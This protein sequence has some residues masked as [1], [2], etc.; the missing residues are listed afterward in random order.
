MPSRPAL[1]P[2]EEVAN[3]YIADDL[4]PTCSSSSS[5]I[6]CTHAAE[7]N[8]LDSDIDP[9]EDD[10][11]AGSQRDME[12]SDLMMGSVWTDSK[13]SSYLNFM[14]QNFVR[15]LYE[16]EYCA[17]DVCGQPSQRHEPRVEEAFDPDSAQSRSAAP[18]G[19]MEFKVWENGNWTRRLEWK[20]KVQPW[21]L[22]SNPWV[23]HFRTRASCRSDMSITSPAPNNG[24]DEPQ[25]LCSHHSNIPNDIQGSRAME[26]GSGG[27]YSQPE[28]ECCTEKPF[29]QGGPRSLQKRTAQVESEQA[30]SMRHPAQF[31]LDE[32]SMT[33]GVFGELCKRSDN[34]EEHHY[35]APYPLPLCGDG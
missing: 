26:V 22:L 33:I 29:V 2:S 34:G 5:G 6:T 35:Y 3:A 16:R 7:V 15:D 21:I 1:V 4:Q 31:C 28:A 13:H 17:L 10:D 32:G 8:E 24:E 20:R 9:D 25:T 18:F 14:E 23:K 27:H 11:T 12:A 19:S 30:S